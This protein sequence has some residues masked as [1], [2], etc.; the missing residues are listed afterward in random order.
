MI[1][2]HRVGRV[3]TFDMAFV[4]QTVAAVLNLFRT[5]SS[6]ATT[7]STR[8]SLATFSFM[9]AVILAVIDKIRGAALLGALILAASPEKGR[10]KQEK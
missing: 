10:A 5:A 7:T 1:S 4:L 6:I 3:A 8:S 9:H 2:T